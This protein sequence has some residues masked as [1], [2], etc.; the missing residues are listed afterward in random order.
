MKDR[1]DLR[2]DE[3]GYQALLISIT[4]LLLIV[5]INWGV[6][7]SADQE[8]YETLEW[9]ISDGEYDFVEVEC[10][11]NECNV[12][13]S[14]IQEDFGNVSVFLLSKSNYIS[15]QSCSEFSV[16]NDL[17]ISN[18]ASYAFKTDVIGG[19]DYYLVVDYG[20]CENGENSS[21]PL[22]T[23]TA[24]VST[25]PRGFFERLFS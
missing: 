1:G 18:K 14:F 9:E 20:L 10:L 8:F 2:K 19:G 17:T 21:S 6:A 13:I 24:S 25:E 3:S 12:E 16:I 7:I 15:Y 4:F 23:G 11:V 22:S 5:M